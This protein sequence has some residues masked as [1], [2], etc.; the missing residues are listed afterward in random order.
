MTLAIT[1]FLAASGGSGYVPRSNLES[2]L[3]LLS[4]LLIFIV[5]LA[6]TIFTTKWIAGYQKQQ[7]ANG[8]IELL[9]AVRLNGNK[10]IQLVRIGEVYVALA[11]CKDTVT[12]IAEIPVEQIKFS[13]EQGKT[14]RFADL[15][16]KLKKAQGQQSELP[17][18]DSK[19]DTE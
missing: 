19:D 1:G 5:V 8:N 6:A 3:E 2:F 15:L 10:Y 12:T 17:Q 9:D 13:G 7:G 16:N 4:V 11:V 14:V 18:D